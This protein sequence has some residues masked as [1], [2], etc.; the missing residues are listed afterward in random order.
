MSTSLNGRVVVVTGGNS[1]IGLGMARGVA[2]AGADV[3][4]WGRRSESNA[5]AAKEISASTGARCLA[6]ECDSSDEEQ[7]EATFARSVSDAGRGDSFF[8][9]A[10]SS[11]APVKF[12]DLTLANW[13]EVLSVNLDGTFRCLRAAAR[14]MVERGGV[15]HWSPPRRCPK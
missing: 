1:G 6:Y 15:D 12:T 9:N 13:R 7:V 8:A 2:R 11:A 14:H 10:G 5:D 4:I 3:V